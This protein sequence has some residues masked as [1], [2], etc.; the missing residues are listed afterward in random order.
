MGGT[1][2]AAPFCGHLT[3]FDK[4]R[5]IWHERVK[6]HRE[7]PTVKYPRQAPARHLTLS[8]PNNP[9]PCQRSLASSA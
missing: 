1:F 6:E 3:V 8:R 5:D 2:R 7:L 4:L 9:T